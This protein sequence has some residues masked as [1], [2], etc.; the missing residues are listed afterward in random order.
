MKQSDKHNN[1]RRDGDM[2]QLAKPGR[3]LPV[4]SEEKSGRFIRKSNQK[5]LTRE[6]LEMCQ[7][8]SDLFKKEWN[9]WGTGK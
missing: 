1:A 3:R 8:S 4:I 7:E 5:K 9:Q 6:Y 2:A